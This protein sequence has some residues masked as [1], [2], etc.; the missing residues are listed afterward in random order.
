MKNT[1]NKPENT[2]SPSLQ[3]FLDRQQKTRKREE[4]FLRV[5][6]LSLLGL[7][8]YY[9]LHIEEVS[10]D[11]PIQPQQ[12]QK[13]LSSPDASENLCN[14]KL[15]SS[16]AFN[17]ENTNIANY[18][19]EQPLV[20]AING[21]NTPVVL[22]LGNE[23]FTI[24]SHT[25]VLYP[26]ANASLQI[27]V[28]VY[29]LTLLTGQTW[30]NFDTGFSDG[31]RVKISRP[32]VVIAGQSN[33]IKL[34][35]IVA[36]HTGV[37]VSMV[38]V[39]TPV[40]TKENNDHKIFANGTLE[41]NRGDNGGFYVNGTVNKIPAN[42]QIDT[43]ASITSIPK[44]LANRAGIFE[45]APRTFNTANGSVIGCVGVAKELVFGNFRF[46]GFEVAIMP[47]MDGVLLGMN[48]LKHLRLESSQDVMR[49]SS[50]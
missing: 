43:G 13:N 14:S 34:D 36:N 40:L 3:R 11:T 30:C 10:P 22:L 15:P 50:S 17:L 42:Y 28:G 37:H 9:K 6:A 1:N 26:G 27:P 46:T 45:C 33:T 7:F 49:L 41:L 38:H 18:G 48:V 44:E 31:K 23:G 39:I 35:S 21:Y 5:L 2:E 32:I 12:M 47:N 25:F 24:Y 8:L 16:R 20:D 4:L 29:G 19:V